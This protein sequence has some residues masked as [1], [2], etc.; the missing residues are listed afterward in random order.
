[1]KSYLCIV[2]LFVHVEWV[3]H[4]FGLWVM[5]HLWLLS[6]LFADFCEVQLFRRVS[7]LDL[8]RDGANVLLRRREEKMGQ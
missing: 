5:R 3:L 4:I 7:F 8:G 6:D 2:G 1:M